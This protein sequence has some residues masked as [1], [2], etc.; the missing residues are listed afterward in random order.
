M[1]LHIFNPEHDLAL[2]G[3]KSGF[4]A[5]HAARA[6][7]SDLGYIPALWACGGDFVLVENKE[8]AYKALKKLNARLGYIGN[9]AVR[10]QVVFIEPDE[11]CR[12]DFDDIV[13]WGWDAPLCNMLVRKGVPRNCLPGLET[14]SSIRMVSHRSTSV[15]LLSELTAIHGT[16]GMSSVCV[17]EDEIV[18]KVEEYGGAAVIKSPWSCSGRGVRF[19][20]TQTLPAFS[21]WIRNTLKRQDALVVEPYYK[22]VKDFGMEFVSHGD[23]R[24]EYCGLSL[25]CTSNGAY[26]GN[27][28]ATEHTKLEALKRYISAGLLGL[29]R[30]RICELLG[31]QLAGCYK[32][33][34]GIDMMVVSNGNDGG[35]MLHPCVEINLRRTMGHVALSLSPD[36]DDIRKIMRITIQDN[37]K[38]RINNLTTKKL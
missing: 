36:D 27:L 28:L 11:L 34:F 7:R 13:P 3:N 29:V 21:G 10:K 31:R 16:I 37:Y 15:A 18:G 2:A 5:P 33:P 14:L 1:V 4:T 30:N 25:F 9:D 24:V 35:Y 26:I 6:L 8:Y 32:G 22:K 17:S 20:S 23:G 38:L 19:V 12:H